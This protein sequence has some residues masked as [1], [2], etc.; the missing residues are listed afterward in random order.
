MSSVANFD[1]CYRTLGLSEPPFRITPD[2][3]FFFPH[4]QHLSA[5]SH[6]RFGMLTGGFTV[7]TAEVGLGKTL[8]CRHLLSSLPEGIRTAYVYNPQLSFLEL[9]RSIIHDLDEEVPEGATEAS[10][11]V[12]MMEILVKNASNGIRVAVLVDEAH[13]LDVSVL[14]G[15]RLLS[16][17]ETEKNKLLSLLLVGQPELN[18]VLKRS[19]MR[20]L[21]ER[22][23]V[24]KRLEPFG[25]S[26]TKRYIHHRLDSVRENFELKFTH[27]AIRMVH[28]YSRGVPRRINL[29]CD[30]AL[31]TVFFEQ[32]LRVNM[33]VVRRAARE[34]MGLEVD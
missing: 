8:L 17:L 14:E 34:V 33:S 26:D 18:K 4:S 24:W 6:L 32:S 5:L 21:R 15:L 20:A 12:F 28:Y 22:I 11:Q 9:M 16:N 25:F 7:L 31:L 30:R 27:G 2:T 13:Q 10:L 3:Q 1:A 19:E 29:I 23:S